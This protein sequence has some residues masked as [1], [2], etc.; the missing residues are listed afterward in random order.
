MGSVVFRFTSMVDLL[1]V[2]VRKLCKD[3]IDDRIILGQGAKAVFLLNEVQADSF[4]P[5]ELA[6]LGE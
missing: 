5:V 3:L 2:K 4:I 1:V 6:N